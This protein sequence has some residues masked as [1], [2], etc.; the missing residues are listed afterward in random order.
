MFVQKN[1]A[2]SEVS[3]FMNPIECGKNLSENLTRELFANI[4]L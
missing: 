4:L 2:E 1:T 3:N